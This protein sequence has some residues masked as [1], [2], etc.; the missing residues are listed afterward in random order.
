MLLYIERY[1]NGE[2]SPSNTRC[3]AIHLY[4]DIDTHRPWVYA[5]WKGP[6]RRA[7]GTGGATYLF[8][9]HLDVDIETVHGCMPTMPT[10]W[11]PI[12]SRR[13]TS[14]TGGANYFSAARGAH[15]IQDAPTYR[16]RN[17]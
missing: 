15:A 7:S 3:D 5:T 4:I 6:R 9:M 17:I 1:R 11:I 14:G 12:C 10:V 16:Y 8:K 13:R 2:L